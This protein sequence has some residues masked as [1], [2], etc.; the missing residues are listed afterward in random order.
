MSNRC[1]NPDSCSVP[2]S[3][4]EVFFLRGRFFSLSLCSDCGVCQ[5]G[6]GTRVLL[7]L[8]WVRCALGALAGETLGWPQGA[9]QRGACWSGAGHLQALGLL[10]GCSAGE[11]RARS[12]LPCDGEEGGRVPSLGGCWS[13]CVN[14]HCASSSSPPAP[15]VFILSVEELTGSPAG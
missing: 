8:C 13:W 6:S 10:R 11:P 7:L 3:E 1:F 2:L 9:Q 5:H 14:N 4:E 15:R 12:L